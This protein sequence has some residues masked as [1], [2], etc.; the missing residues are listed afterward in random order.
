MADNQ[1]NVTTP[2]TNGKVNVTATTTTINTTATNT[3]ALYYSNLSKNWAIKMDGKVLDEDYSSKYY[4]SIAEQNAQ[5]T[6]EN[7]QICTSLND[8]ITSNFN[9]YSESLS[10]QLDNS[11]SSIQE[12]E[13]TSLTNLRDKESV[14]IESITT[15]NTNS[16]ADISTAQNE[17]TNAVSDTKA[18]SITELEET[19]STIITELETKGQSERDS[20]Q[21]DTE[22]TASYR[23]EA[24]QSAED[25]KYWAEISTAGQI[26]ADWEQTDTQSKAYI[27]NKPDLTLKADVSYVDTELSEKQDKLTAGTGIAISDDNVISNTGANTDLSNLTSEGE[28]HFLNKTQLTNC[29]LEAPNG[30]A[31]YEGN[32]ITVK[33][34]LKVLMPNGINADGTFKNIEYTVPEDISYTTTSSGSNMLL[35]RS[36]G[37]CVATA[38]Q[39]Y[40]RQNYTPSATTGWWYNTYKNQCYYTDGSSWNVA[41]VPVVPILIAKEL[42]P[43]QD[44]KTLQPVNLIKTSDYEYICGL[45]MPSNRHLTLT[46]GASGSTYTAPANGYYSVSKKVTAADQYLYFSSNTVEATVHSVASS[47]N[48]ENYIPALKGSSVTISYTAKGD[49]SRFFFVYAEGEK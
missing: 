48:L 15:A 7:A 2:S 10:N 30:V 20:I 34:G 5:S 11:L 38:R 29:I 26:Q 40:F 35:L 18:K 46:L 14:A 3:E 9:S 41:S 44:F 42:Y 39:Y 4:A 32:T 13:Q 37:T 27:Q 43:I 23:D 47:N 22:L 31:T 6:T 49:T 19:K 24:K 36:N 8:T 21:A 12:Q 33:A 1:V 45:G 17:A 16:L 28:K 25:S